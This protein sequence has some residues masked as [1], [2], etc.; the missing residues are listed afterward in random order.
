MKNNI[1]FE[2]HLNPH[3]LNSHVSLSLISSNPISFT[4]QF[5]KFLWIRSCWNH[6]CTK[7]R[8]PLSSPPSSPQSDLIIGGC[9]SS[10]C[11]TCS[12]KL[13]LT[14]ICGTL[15]S[16]ELRP[17]SATLEVRQSDWEV[18]QTDWNGPDRQW[19]SLRVAGH[20]SWIWG[21]GGYT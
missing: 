15:Y 9:G 1:T 4:S 12:V 7:L 16:V 19:H 11:N 5:L 10:S 17:S 14:V 20:N 3:L 8:V 13:S 18:R 21:G 6:T 2:S